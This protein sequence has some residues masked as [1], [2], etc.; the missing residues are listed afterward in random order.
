MEQTFRELAFGP[1]EA[2]NIVRF[3]SSLQ[4]FGSY[5]EIEF[6]LSCLIFER[7]SIE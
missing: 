1:L 2:I 5:K 4:K 6:H 7:T 3:L